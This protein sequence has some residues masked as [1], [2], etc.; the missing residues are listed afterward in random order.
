MIVRMIGISGEQ[1]KRA[2]KFETLA[3]RISNARVQRVVV[4]VGIS[5][6]R[7]HHG[8]HNVA[9]RSFHDNI[10]CEVRRNT[11]RLAQNFFELGKLVVVWHDAHYQQISNFFEAESIAQT[12]N[13]LCN[14]VAAIPQLTRAR[15]FF[16]V[17]D[18]ATD[19]SRNVRQAGKDAL[20]VR[21][22]QAALN[23]VLFVQRG[24]DVI[25][26][27]YQVNLTLCIS[28]DTQQ[29]S[30]SIQLHSLKNSFKLLREAAATNRDEFS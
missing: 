2:D 23:S 12:F 8:F 15:L 10:A 30:S 21:I 13:Q 27:L 20:T 22:T 25:I 9:G 1:R 16:S 11:P 4:V 24:I 29:N 3:Q 7:A 14:F 17:N 6:N 19:D 18:S 26:T 28:F 5:K